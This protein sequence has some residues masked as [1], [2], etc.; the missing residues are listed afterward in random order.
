MDV[1][2]QINNSSSANAQFVT[3][4]PSPCRIRVTNPA[5]APGPTANVKLS[6]AS[7]ANGG[8]VGFRSG[9][10]GSF[11]STLTLNVPTNGTSV[12]FFAAGKFGQPSTNLGD[13]KIEARVGNALVGSTKVMVRIR[14]NAT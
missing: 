9:S 12:A 14:K 4:A 6:A 7:A 10:S 13:V 1:E 3:W 2:L 5:G 8:A 11:A